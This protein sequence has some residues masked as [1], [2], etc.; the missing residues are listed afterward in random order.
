[1]LIWNYLLTVS[2]ITMEFLS[3]YSFYGTML[4]CV[5]AKESKTCI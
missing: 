4:V 2:C 1:M 5:K 3:L